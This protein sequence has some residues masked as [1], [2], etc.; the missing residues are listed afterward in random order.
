MGC[1]DTNGSASRDLESAAG[2]RTLP[3]VELGHFVF[4]Q[5]FFERS[6]TRN[7]VAQSD[8][9]IR[10]APAGNSCTGSSPGRRERTSPGG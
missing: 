9:V 8:A 4:D 3:K 10:G 2:G 6:R 7:Q 5:D 1:S